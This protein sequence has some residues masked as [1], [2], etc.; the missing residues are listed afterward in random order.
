LNS[1]IVSTAFA[2]LAFTVVFPRSA[3]SQ[4]PTAETLM[5][6]ASGIAARDSQIKVTAEPK[7]GRA[8]SLS[9]PATRGCDVLL[10]YAPTAD[11]DV[12]AGA[13]IDLKLAPRFVED[14]D[15]TQPAQP[16]G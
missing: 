15:V 12:I 9:D 5:M 8:L 4:T 3:F 6:G 7:C 16:V 11:E 1:S 2:I 14:A 13:I 10:Y